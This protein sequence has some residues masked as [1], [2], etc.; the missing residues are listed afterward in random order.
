MSPRGD[1]TRRSKKGPNNGELSILKM[2]YR[3]PL[4]QL[5]FGHGQTEERQPKSSQE[6]LKNCSKAL[7]S[8]QAKP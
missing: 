3:A 8:L 2:L 1:Y 5:S 7:A 6:I 4:S